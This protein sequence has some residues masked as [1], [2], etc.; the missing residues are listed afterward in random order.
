MKMVNG[1][2]W[3][4]LWCTNEYKCE[5]KWIQMHEWNAQQMLFHEPPGRI[6]LEN[7]LD[8]FPGH[9]DTGK[10]MSSTDELDRRIYMSSKKGAFPNSYY[11]GTDSNWQWNYCIFACGF[12]GGLSAIL[13]IY[14]R[15]G[16]EEHEISH[17][18]GAGCECVER[19]ESAGR[20][21][22]RVVFIKYVCRRVTMSQV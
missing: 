7:F 1:K 6:N 10:K 19:C 4:D 20:A 3:C 9:G 16:T 2:G 11:N 14:T 21:E 15:S 18:S 17:R 12:Q 8:R 5:Y 13:T 22:Q